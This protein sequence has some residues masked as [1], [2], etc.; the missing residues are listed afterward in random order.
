MSESPA[1][2]SALLPPRF[3]RGHKNAS[4][5]SS[6]AASPPQP[7]FPPG[8]AVETVDGLLPPRRISQ[9]F[10]V[11]QVDRTIGRDG[12]FVILPDA[13]G[14]F[15]KVNNQTPGM[16]WKPF[17][18][19]RE[20]VARPCATASSSTWSRSHWG[21]RSSSAFSGSQS[22]G[23]SDVGQVSSLS[24]LQASSRQAGILAH[25]ESRAGRP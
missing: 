21:L 12:P 8:I 5:G 2:T 9:R 20:P 4:T 1:Q 3:V 17:G 10:S 18:C 14:G 6:P 15:R 19:A 16:E 23:T 7:L 24:T 22:M 25:E 11:A 13:S